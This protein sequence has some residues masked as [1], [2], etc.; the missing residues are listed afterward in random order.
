[1]SRLFCNFVVEKRIN[2]QPSRNTAIGTL[3]YNSIIHS[4]TPLIFNRHSTQLMSSFRT[5]PTTTI[6]PTVSRTMQ[7]YLLTISHAFMKQ[8]Y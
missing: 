2:F 5:T 6:A 4:M 3:C 8:C 1:M 7:W